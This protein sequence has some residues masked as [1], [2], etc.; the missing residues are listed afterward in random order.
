MNTYI[1][2]TRC[3]A[4]TSTK[5]RLKDISDSSTV[6]L[7]FYSEK[8]STPLILFFSQSIAAQGIG[9]MWV[10][11]GDDPW[12]TFELTIDDL[13]IGLKTSG[14]HN[15]PDVLA[16]HGVKNHRYVLFRR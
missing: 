14:H 12:D 2:K 1:F 4:L 7:A 15:C 5:M 11:K 6:H 16:F 3:S 10:L 8:K 9:C 13:D